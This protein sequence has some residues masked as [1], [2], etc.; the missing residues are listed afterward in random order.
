M[1]SQLVNVLCWRLTKI[2][3]QNL[4]SLC[5]FL[6]FPLVVHFPSRGRYFR[7]KKFR[8]ISERSCEKLNH[9]YLHQNLFKHYFHLLWHKLSFTCQQPALPSLLLSHALFL[10]FLVPS[11]GLLGLELLSLPL[12]FWFLNILPAQVRSNRLRPLDQNWGI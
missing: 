10:A 5:F 4:L 8:R 1:S 3:V 2:Q 11:C 7:R 12:R 6:F 9:D